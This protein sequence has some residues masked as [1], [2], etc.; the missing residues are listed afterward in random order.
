MKNH[1]LKVTS[2]YYGDCISELY[3]IKTSDDITDEF[4]KSEIEKWDAILSSFN[5]TFININSFEFD[6][7]ETQTEALTQFFIENLPSDYDEKEMAELCTKVDVFDGEDP[8]DI[9]NEEGRSFSTLCKYMFKEHED[10]SFD[11][12]IASI[13]VYFE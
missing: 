3:C 1:I 9:Y 5:D 11:Y 2:P 8:Y 4:I 7:Y 13:D 12:S 10:W 6:D